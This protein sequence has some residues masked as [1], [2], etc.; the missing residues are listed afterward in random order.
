MQ[1]KN[2]KNI[3][4]I[5]LLNF[6]LFISNLNAEEFNISAKEIVVDK[7]N[8]IVIGKGSVQVEDSGGK[9]IYADKVIYEKLREFLLME[10]NVKITDYEGNILKTGKATYDKINEIIVTFGNTE[11]SLKEGLRRTIS[12]HKNYYSDSC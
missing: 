3:I 1:I 2:K 5:C 12:W 9:I 4:V 7:A 6:F 8:E 10:G 11:I